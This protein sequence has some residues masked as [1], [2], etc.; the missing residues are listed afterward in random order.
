MTLRFDSLRGRVRKLE[1]SVVSLWD[2][3][4]PAFTVQHSRAVASSAPGA[5]ECWSARRMGKMD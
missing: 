5:C 1:K 3:I 2:G 4:S